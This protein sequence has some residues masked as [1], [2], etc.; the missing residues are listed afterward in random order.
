MDP[1]AG[2]PTT[3]ATLRATDAH[4]VVAADVLDA[5]RVLGDVLV[6][7]D[8]VAQHLR[9]VLRLRSGASV[10]VTDLAGRWCLAVV[11]VTT[12]PSARSGTV[13]RIVG[14][15]VHEPVPPACAIAAAMPKGDRLEW[16][17]Q[18][19][20]ELGVMRLTL[21]H[22]DRSVVRWS[23]DRVE[24]H[25]ARLH[26]IME[27]ACRQSR[28][29]WA[30]T[31]DGPVAST[32]FLADGVT[33]AEP[34]GAPIG[35]TDRVVAIGPEGGWSESELACARR[36]VSLGDTVLRTETAAIAAATLCVVN[37]HENW[38]SRPQ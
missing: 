24:R 20:T 9:R 6:P 26:R 30:M 3:S 21:L 5:H 13:L 15:L 8:E 10:S 37:G 23:P 4:V 34:G 31:I 35:P 38:N 18:K 2:G 33:I 19:L 14:E 11:D 17:V 12:T 1:S 27:E 36:R 16:M 32:T 25:L 22:A 7:T 28:R 29:C